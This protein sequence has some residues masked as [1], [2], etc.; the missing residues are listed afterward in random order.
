[1]PR[2][3][4]VS[5]RALLLGAGGVALLGASA[6]SFRALAA[7]GPKQADYPRDVEFLLAEL[8][9][10]AGHFFPGKGVDW[11]KVAAE[12]RIEVKQV[13]TDEEH[14]KLCQRLLARLRDGHA[15]IAD[16]KIK[17]RDESKG[18][19]FTGPRVHLLTVGEEVYVRAAFKE[20]GGQGI[21][22]GMKVR[23]IDGLPAREWLGKKV[24]ELRDST[25]YSTDH[26]AL[27]AACHGGLAD[28]EGTRIAFELEGGSGAKKVTLTRRG[29]PNFAPLGPVHPPAGLKTL[30]RHS[31]GKTSGGFG[32]IDLRDVPGELPDQL[33]RMLEDL[34]EVPGLI[35]DLRANGGGGCDHEAVFGRFLA[36]G[37]RWRQYSG[38]SRR[39]HLGPMVVIID[40]GVRSA[41][42]TVAGMFGE[43]GRAY[44]IGDSPTAGMSAQK[45]RLAVPSGLLTVSFAV[46]SNKL[47][48]NR[49]KGIEGIGVPPME[50]VPYDPVELSKGIDTQIRRAE[51]LLRAGFPEGRVA[52]KGR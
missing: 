14:L 52:Y 34:G 42:E 7:A 48:F 6:A 35:L 28:W 16:S 20:A 38:Q 36:A 32:Y 17:P 22:V 40:A 23:R 33:D 43:D 8:E 21:R 5:R 26:Q 51:E 2:I 44:L 50:T 41:G 18:R 37:Q 13:K 12:F 10:K 31:Y 49:G 9:K 29:G 11:K 39:P 30:G 19:R 15:A 47:R 4:A 3:G 24:A 45:E 25:G 46:H 27:Y 1:M